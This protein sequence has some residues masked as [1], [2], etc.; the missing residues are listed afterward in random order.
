[1]MRVTETTTIEKSKLDPHVEE[2]DEVSSSSF[3]LRTFLSIIFHVLVIKSRSMSA[4]K[5]VSADKTT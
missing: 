5:N 3:F 1:V 4:D 2:V